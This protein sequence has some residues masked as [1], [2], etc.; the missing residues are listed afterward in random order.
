M[1]DDIP[2]SSPTLRLT[3]AGHNFVFGGSIAAT[4]SGSV[5][6]RLASPLERFHEV[7]EDVCMTPDLMA[8][9]VR[10]AGMEVEAQHNA[11]IGDALFAQE[12]KES[13]SEVKSTLFERKKKRVQEAAAE[14]VA[15]L[16]AKVL[17]K[18]ARQARV[19]MKRALSKPTRLTK[20]VRDRFGN[21]I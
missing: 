20:R 10:I 9:A 3:K 11:R 18:Q 21:R 8:A 15:A 1:A 4:G 5:E 2:F 13:M 16:E 19:A 17:A 14:A 12:A 7:A 6:R